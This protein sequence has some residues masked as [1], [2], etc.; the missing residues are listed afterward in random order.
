MNMKE[1]VKSNELHVTIYREGYHYEQFHM[2]FTFL[3]IQFVLKSFVYLKVQFWSSLS[4]VSPYFK[5]YNVNLLYE[6]FVEGHLIIGPYQLPR[7]VSFKNRIRFVEHM[8]ERTFI[9]FRAV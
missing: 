4:I 2:E 5:V 7:A 3:Y 9:Q 8:F 1:K 6:S